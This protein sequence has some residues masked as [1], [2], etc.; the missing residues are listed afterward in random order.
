[1]ATSFTEN[2][3]HKFVGNLSDGEQQVC[4]KFRNSIGAALSGQQSFKRSSNGS[5][6]RIVRASGFDYDVD[7]AIASGVF[8]PEGPERGS[9]PQDGE[10]TVALSTAEKAFLED[11]EGLIEWTIRNGVSFTVVLQILGHDI[12]ELARD[13]FDLEKAMGPGRRVS[14]KVTG[15]ARRNLEPVGE[16]DEQT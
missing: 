14:P 7:K 2:L 13:E 8:D 12:H 3:K 5:L 6:A 4:E 16:A 10:D 9:A 1:M 15:W 11:A